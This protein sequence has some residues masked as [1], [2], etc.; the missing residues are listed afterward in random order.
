MDELRKTMSTRL[1]NVAIA[2]A[3]DPLNAD[4]YDKIKDYLENQA[5]ELLTANTTNSLWR[6]GADGKMYKADPTKPRATL[7]NNAIQQYEA[8]R[9]DDG[10][11]QDAY[12]KVGMA[13]DPVTSTWDATNPNK[14]GASNAAGNWIPQTPVGVPNRRP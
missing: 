4:K 8:M 5:H 13:Y 7:H 9:R 3:K 12:Y 2:K 6:V 10:S 14:F 1:D 11:L